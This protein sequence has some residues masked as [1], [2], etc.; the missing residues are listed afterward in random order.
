MKKAM[1]IL[2]TFIMVLQLIPIPAF[3]TEEIATAEDLKAFLEN[4]ENVTVAEGSTLTVQISAENKLTKV[5]VF[6]DGEVR[7]KKD[8]TIPSAVKLQIPAATLYFHVDSTI[9][10]FGCIQDGRAVADR[11]NGIVGEGDGKVVFTNGSV[12]F[13]QGVTMI[14]TSNTKLKLADDDSTITMYKNGHMMISS[15]TVNLNSVLT[16]DHFKKITV[17]V[18]AIFND[19]GYVDAGIEFTTVSNHGGVLDEDIEKAEKLLA[20][21]SVSSDGSDIDSDSLWVTQAAHDTYSAAIVAAQTAAETG[22]DD[23]II[24]AI[25][26]LQEATFRFHAEKEQGGADIGTLTTYQELLDALNAIQD[27]CA[28]YKGEED[29]GDQHYEVIQITK[30][31]TIDQVITVPYPIKLQFNADIT[32]NGRIIIEGYLQDMYLSAYGIFGKEGVGDV[33]FNPNTWMYIKGKGGV[34]G[35]TSGT[36]VKDGAEMLLVGDHGMI[37]KEGEVEVVTALYS[38]IAEQVYCMENT[39]ITLSSGI[40]EAASID[41]SNAGVK[42]VY[43]GIENTKNILGNEAVS[44]SCLDN[45]VSVVLE[46]GRIEITVN[47]KEN[48]GNAEIVFT[49]VNG[50]FGTV[51]IVY[52]KGAITSAKVTQIGFLTTNQAKELIAELKAEEPDGGGSD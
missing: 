7:I 50:G 37:I 46:D 45:A 42:F 16:T 35:T 26:A 12:Y 9:T 43:C 3:A 33:L 30:P 6:C 23:V 41:A 15:G 25:E 29:Y 49:D 39:G 34:V 52:A 36:W 40:N 51:E 28:V 17:A 4:P 32:I 47:E 19:G 31:I 22:D 8:V 5:S 1:T 13:Q 21:V 44:V 48:A 18:D 2:L 20:F 14:N 27:G 10:V 24:A 38:D 11:A